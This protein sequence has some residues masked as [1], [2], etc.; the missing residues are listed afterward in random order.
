M[1]SKFDLKMIT[2]TLMAQRDNLR[3]IAALQPNGAMG[4]AVQV[5]LIKVQRY[6]VQVTHVDTGSLRAAHRMELD[7]SG[8]R[9][10]VF[11]DP[12]ASNPRAKTPVWKYGQ[13]EHKRGGSHAF[14]D[15]TYNALGGSVL[16]QAIESIWR[17]IDGR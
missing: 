6:A 14:Y 5:A 15:R 11:I 10:A 1:S 7:S 8:L 16:D 3:A 4:A 9:G 2:E 17:A 13:E 12:S